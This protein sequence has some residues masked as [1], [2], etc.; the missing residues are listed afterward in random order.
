MPSIK[1]VGNHDAVEVAGLVVKRGESA[2]FPAQIA[3]SLLDQPDNWQ[4][5]EAVAKPPKEK[6]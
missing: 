4:P 3:K 6:K 5:A 2:D 1:Y